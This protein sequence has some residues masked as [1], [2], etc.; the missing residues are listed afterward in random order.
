MEIIDLILISAPITAIF[1]KAL[2][3]SAQN[4]HDLDDLSMTDDPLIAFLLINS[5]IE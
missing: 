4:D 2:I 3:R 5:I 1:S